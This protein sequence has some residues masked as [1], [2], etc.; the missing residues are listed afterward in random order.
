MLAGIEGHS[1]ALDPRRFQRTSPVIGIFTPK[2]LSWPTLAAAID[3]C[4]QHFRASQ[5]VIRWHP[6]MLES[7]RLAR[8]LADRSGIGT[9]VASPA[10]S[11]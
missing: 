2:A 5:I 9:P 8:H 11:A 6:S 7:P 3:D 4:R 1:V 10:A